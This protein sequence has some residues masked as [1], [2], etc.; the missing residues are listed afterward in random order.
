MSRKTASFSND[1]IINHADTMHQQYDGPVPDTS[2]A[3]PF[4]FMVHG[5][6]NIRKQS[7]E[8]HYKTFLGEQKT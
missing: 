7:P 5:P 1:Y 8:I 3:V 4:R 6:F 2:N